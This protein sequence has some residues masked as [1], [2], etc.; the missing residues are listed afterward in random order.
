MSDQ[1][2][3]VIVDSRGSEATPESIALL[4]S[5]GFRV[6]V[7]RQAA[8]EDLIRVGAEADGLIFAGGIS[9]PVMENLTRCRV[10]AR[11]GIGMDTVEAIDVATERG[12]VL[13]NMPNV[14]EEEVADQTLALLL[15]CARRVVTLDRYVR[16]G[17]WSRREPMPPEALTSPRISGSTLGLIGLGQIARAVARRMSGFGVRVIAHDPYLDAAV[18]R[19]LG[20]KQATVAEVLQ[21]SNFV[22]IHCPLMD[23]TRHLIGRPELRMM[24]PDAILINTARGPIVDQEALVEALREGWIAGAGID[25]METEPI[26]EDDPLRTLPNVV[27]S[28]HSAS[29]S[30]FT[31]R[32]RRLRP[33]QEVIA[34]LSGH[35]PRAVWNREVLRQLSLR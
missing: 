24:R 31:E 8:D 14:I 27:L 4:E 21:D 18:F 10:I 25:V 34:V 2:L 22:S 12:I 17:G 3:V 28:P 9:R 23:T 15:A 19:E 13:C 32:E 35:L 26:P 1:K 30:V 11:S 33:A 29:R 7:C 16:D 6:E 20:A 5:A